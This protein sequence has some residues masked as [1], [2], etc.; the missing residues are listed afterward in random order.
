VHHAKGKNFGRNGTPQTTWAEEIAKVK[1]T[2]TESLT[3]S[4]A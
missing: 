3:L 1:P 2:I 4:L